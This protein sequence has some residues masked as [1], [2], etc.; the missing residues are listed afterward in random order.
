MSS[1]N[2]G[3]G[4][5]PRHRGE[6]GPGKGPRKGSA[7]DLADGSRPRYPIE[8]GRYVTEKRA[9]VLLKAA[10]KTTRECAEI[11]GITDRSIHRWL[12]DGLADEVRRVQ[13]EI[14]DAAKSVLTSNALK[15]AE[16]LVKLTE[17]AGKNDGPKVKACVEALGMAGV[18][19][20]TVIEH[21]TVDDLDRLSDEELEERASRDVRKE[22]IAELEAKGW[23]RPEAAPVVKTL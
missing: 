8:D 12:Q 3:P 5:P 18:V 11:I 16:R 7:L 14:V 4:D 15:V 10:G 19:R 1:T 22:V 17:D 20:R 13:D 2:K 6:R 9:V 23:R 21:Q